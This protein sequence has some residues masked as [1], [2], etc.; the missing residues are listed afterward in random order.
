METIAE[1]RLPW[2]PNYNLRKGNKSGFDYIQGEVRQLCAEHGVRIPEGSQI[3]LA[4]E[5]EDGL[6]MVRATVVR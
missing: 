6:K 5:V 4:V 3:R 2:Q 1:F